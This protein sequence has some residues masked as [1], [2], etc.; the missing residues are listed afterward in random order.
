MTRWGSWRDE[1]FAEHYWLG[2]DLG[3]SGNLPGVLPEIFRDLLDRGRIDDF[4]EVLNHRKK[5]SEVLTPPR[6][7]KATG[8]LLAHRGGRLASVREV[9][10][11]AG[12][13]IRRRRLNRRPA[14]V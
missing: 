13:D 7:L 6:L 11:L 8:R 3:R 12:D 14:Y 4:L 9:A 10:G 1:E 5:P 2:S